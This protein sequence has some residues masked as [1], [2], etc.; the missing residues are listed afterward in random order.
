MVRHATPVLGMYIIII[1]G[2]LWTSTDISQGAE[3][4]DPCVPRMEKTSRPVRI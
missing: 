2:H 3:A 1:H 4:P